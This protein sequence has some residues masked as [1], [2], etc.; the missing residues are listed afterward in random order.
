MRVFM[1]FILAI[2]ALACGNKSTVTTAEE[3][4]VNE[5]SDVEIPEVPAIEIV[6]NLPKDSGDAYTIRETM[7]YGSRLSIVLTYGGGCKDH[8]FQLFTTGAIMKSMPP[9]MQIL[10]FHDGNDDMCR[11]LVTDTVSFD[12]KPVKPQGNGSLIL[13]LQDYNDRIVYNY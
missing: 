3:N 12:L 4:A 8:E 7:V 5:K 11:A 13:R 6:E 2:M 10:L 1:F 9:Q